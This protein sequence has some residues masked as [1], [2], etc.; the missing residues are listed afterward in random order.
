ML[1]F[2]RIHCAGALGAALMGGL[3]PAAD[4]ITMQGGATVEGQVI[5]DVEGDP[6]IV[7][8]T[9]SKLLCVNRS[10]VSAIK[11][12]EEGRADFTRRQ[13]AI[14]GGS[15]MTHFE[16]YK[17]AKSRRL[18][19]CADQELSATI[20]ADPTHEGA[21]KVIAELN[22][23]AQAGR[24]PKPAAGWGPVETVV[25]GQLTIGPRAAPKA[26]RDRNQQEA[27]VLELCQKIHLSAS[28]EEE[29]RRAATAELSRDVNKSGQIMTT[30]LDPQ[31]VPQEDD[32]SAVLSGIDAVKPSGPDLSRRLACAAMGDP[33]EGVRSKT[34]KL[35]K[36]RN[37]EWAIMAMVNTFVDAYGEGGVVKDAG[38]AAAGGAALRALNDKR[39][40]GAIHYY[41]TTEVRTA[42]TELN[43]LVTRQIDAFTVNNGA[44]VAVIIPLSFP[45]Q[46]PELKITGVKTTVCA[47]ATALAALT[48]MNFGND[49]EAWA[50]WIRKQP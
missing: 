33:S 9:G 43:S 15:A 8:N 47:P 21:R 26:S 39:V 27:K 34:I 38:A 3:T 49:L 12:D 5:R 35:I 32:R 31:I 2:K 37:D 14:K 40:L 19:D 11:L 20:K 41:A 25:D 45:I 7:I 24:V 29:S 17:W 23:A 22:A 36:S 50:K 46:F 28:P 4:N 13:E 10:E 42:V 30:L 16:L 18:Y 48:G 6:L 44:N 1:G